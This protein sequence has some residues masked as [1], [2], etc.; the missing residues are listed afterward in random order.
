LFFH[1][2]QQQPQ[3]SLQSFQQSQ[4]HPPL[5]RLWWTRRERLQA[6]LGPDQSQHQEGNL[7]SFLPVRR[8]GFPTRT[9]CK[10]WVR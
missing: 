1:Y 9:L 8:L 10:V 7:G 6:F 4:R 2:G 3:H 5:S